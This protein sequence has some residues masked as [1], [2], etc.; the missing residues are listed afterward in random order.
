MSEVTED[1]QEHEIVDE[2][3]DSEE[4]EIGGPQYD[5]LNTPVIALVGIVSGLVTFICIVG[6]QAAFMQWRTYEFQQK[7]V[8]VR[9]TE[10]D[11][12][13]KMQKQK[14]EPGY[15]W[16]VVPPAE[17]EKPGEKPNETPMAEP[18]KF[19]SMPIDQAMK[20]VAQQYESK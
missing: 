3:A 13:I 12:I 16:V 5:D 14:L 8:N 19:I 4:I 9:L 20:V 18:K 6:L 2:A 7:V 15:E 1:T 10:V 11:D 17:A